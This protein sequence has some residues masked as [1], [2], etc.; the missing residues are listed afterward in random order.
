MTPA[1]DA[2]PR[3]REPNW[4]DDLPEMV[5]R[6]EPREWS[7]AE[8]IERAADALAF[9]RLGAGGVVERSVDRLLAAMQTHLRALSARTD[10]DGLAGE[11]GSVRRHL[12]QF[13]WRSL[14][15]QAWAHVKRCDSELAATI[16]RLRE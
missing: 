6:E 12:D 13:D 2:T 15:P 10:S 11:L 16:A 14:E 8:S 3:P 4:W 5:L 1:G 7:T 9:C